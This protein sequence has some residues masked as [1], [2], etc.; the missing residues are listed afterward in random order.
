V[1]GPARRLAATSPLRPA[2]HRTAAGTGRFKATL[3][4]AAY[5]AG[6]ISAARVDS[7]GREDD[8]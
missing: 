5:S 1:I 4:R 8:W 7:I 3:E 6:R 2:R